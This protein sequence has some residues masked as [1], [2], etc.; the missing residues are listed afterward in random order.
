M[1]RL[2]LV[3]IFLLSTAHAQNRPPKLEPLPE[4]PPPPPLPSLLDE[5][6]VRIP[7][8]TEDRI[9]EVREGGRVVMLKV[10]PPNGPTYYLV[11]TTGNGNW[12][13]RDSLDD[14]VRVPMWPIHTFD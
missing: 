4:P 9:E 8:Q 13:R 6:A 5:P 12:M 14:G 3:G 7:V 2:L 11:D 10:T 1:R